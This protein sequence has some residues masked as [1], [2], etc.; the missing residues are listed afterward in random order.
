MSGLFSYSCHAVVYVMYVCVLV[1]VH[2][3]LYLMAI[4]RKA[5]PD[6]CFVVLSKLRASSDPKDL[7]LCSVVFR[8]LGL[9][10]MA[11]GA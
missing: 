6:V 2:C 8:S 3:H 4:G 10:P 7:L 11:D 1:Y 9:C 5:T